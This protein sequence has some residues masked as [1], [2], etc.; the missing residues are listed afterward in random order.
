M[1]T[2]NAELTPSKATANK[3]QILKELGQ[4]GIGVV[5]L[6]EARGPQGFRKLVVLKMMRS[7]LVGDF[8]SHRMFLE[9]ARVCARLNHPNIVQVYEV[10]EFAEAPTMVMEYLEGQPLSA[11]LSAAPEGAAMPRSLLVYVVTKVLAGLAAAHDMRDFDGTPLRLVHRD[12]SPHNVFVCYDGQVKVLDFGIAKSSSSEVETRVEVSKGKVRCMPPEHFMQLPID[13]R[14]D[15]FTVGVMLWESLAGRRLWGD[16]PDDEVVTELLARRVPAL[17]EDT[18][19]PPELAAICARAMAPHPAERYATA[20]EMQ[21]DLEYFLLRQGQR[22]GADEMGAFLRDR[23]S[24]QRESE[25]SFIESHAR[26]TQKMLE[27]AGTEETRMVGPPGASREGKGSATSIPKPRHRW[28]TFAALPGGVIA[29][30]LVMFAVAS[31]GAR[32]QAAQALR[33]ADGGA[34]DRTGAGGFKSCGGQC[35]SVDRPDHGCGAALCSPCNVGT[36][37]DNCGACGRKCALVP[38]AERGCGD[39]CTTPP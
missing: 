36:D 19:V 37:P 33:P 2:A 35:V 15:I 14:A 26:L 31:Y 18:N 10:V 8:D 32:R 9:E 7:Q 22:V 21:R 11:I 13:R 12:V 20:G 6:A 38:H 27:R 34:A 30:A 16:R 1:M 5:H 39:S 4:G 3:Y 24:A 29:L 28:A 23:F 17:P 25:N